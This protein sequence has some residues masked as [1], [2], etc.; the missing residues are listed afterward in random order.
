M[1]TQNIRQKT[2]GP[3]RKPILNKRL[4]MDENTN[5]D[6]IESEAQL[7]FAKQNTMKNKMNEIQ[8]KK[9]EEDE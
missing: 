4:K 6:L 3:F 2:I 9:N 7:N 8:L 5:S 1:H